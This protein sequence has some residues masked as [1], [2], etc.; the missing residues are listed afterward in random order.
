MRG[1]NKIILFSVS[2]RKGTFFH[3]TCWK[4]RRVFYTI[5]LANARVMCKKLFF[6]RG[7]NSKRNPQERDNLPLNKL[8]IH[9]VI[10]RVG[11]NTD[12]GHVYYKSFSFP[13]YRST[14][15]SFYGLR[16]SA[17]EFVLHHSV[18]HPTDSIETWLGRGDN[19]QSAVSWI[20]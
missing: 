7:W 3:L 18:L 11:P 17:S 14:K 5:V 16:I 1:F 9:L 13:W 8:G 20:C 15:G 10:I 4:R 12:S 6:V 2:F 19:N